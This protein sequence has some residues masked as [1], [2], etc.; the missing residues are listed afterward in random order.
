MGGLAMKLLEAS[1]AIL[2]GTF[3]LLAS[4]LGAQATDGATGTMKP[5]TPVIQQEL[6]PGASDIHCCT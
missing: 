1:A 2:A 6:I 3:T 4:S 5:A